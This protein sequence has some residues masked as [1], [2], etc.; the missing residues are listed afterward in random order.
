MVRLQFRQLVADVFPIWGK[1]MKIPN[2]RHVL[3]ALL[4]LALA[5]G[6]AAAQITT[7]TIT[8]SVKDE[9]GAILPGVSVTVK[10]VDTGITRNVITD[11][12]GNYEASNLSL[13]AYEVTAELSGFQTSVRSGITLTVGRSA[14]VT[15]ALKVGEISEKVTVTGEA[16][17]VETTRSEVAD[18]VST[19]KI[20][21]LPLNGRSYTELALL[22]A[23][24]STLGSSG[25][26]SIA[27][28]GAKLSIAGTRSS[29][30]AFYVD[31]T[32][33]K[34]PFGHSPG[35]AGGQTLGVEAIRE[36]SVLVST[37]SSEY[38]GSG[39]VINSVSKSGTNSIHG[40]VFE[41]LRNSA[42]DARNFF[43]PGKN[44]PPF[45]RNQYGFSIGGPIAKDRTFFF[46][47]YEA[48]K[49]RLATTSTLN[50]PNQRA[51]EG[52]IPDGPGGAE[53][54]YVLHPQ[55][56]KYLD[57]FPLPNGRINN[58]GTGDFI[59]SNSQPTDENFFTIKVDHQLS[60][61]DSVFVRYTFDD[62]DQI[63]P[64]SFPQFYQPLFTRYQYVTIEENKIFSPKWLNT[65][66]FGFNRS[67]GGDI[68]MMRNLDPNLYAVIKLPERISPSLQ[69]TGLSTFGP[70]ATGDRFALVNSFQ[71]TDK[72]SFTGGRHSIRLGTD[73]TRI[74]YNGA[75]RSRIHGNVRFN[76]LRDFFEGRVLL[77]EYMVPG[78]GNLRGFRQNEIAFYVQDD[79]KVTSRFT[80]NLGLRLEFVTIPTE[81]AGRISNVR[82]PLKDKASTVGDPFF[83][84]PKNNWGPRFGFAWDPTG[85]GNMSLRGGFGLFYQ[86]MTYTYW[87]LPAM[88]NDPYFLRASLANTTFPPPWDA[89]VGTPVLQPG[90]IQFDMKTPYV[91]HYN[92]SLQRQ[93]PGQAVITASY[94]GSHGVHIGRFFNQNTNTF[95]IRPDGSKFFLPGPSGT[96]G[97][98]LNP[99]FESVDLRQFDSN[100]LYN[101]FQLRAQ[102]RFA[103]GIQAQG[104][105]TF[106]RSIDEASNDSGL[107]SGCW[108]VT[109][110]DPYD[111]SRDRGLSCFDLR[112]NL[113]LNF[114]YD[115]PGADMRG[116][117]GQLI[118]GWKLGG[119]ANFH[120]GA[121][122]VVI[123]GFQHSRIG[124]TGT[125][126]QA[127]RPN[128]KPGAS[129]N[130][131]L[132]GPDRYLDPSSFVLQEAGTMGDLGR[133]TIISPG[134]AT[135]NGSLA[136]DFRITE[137]RKVEFRAE[138]FNLFNRANF[139]PANGSVFTSA[140][141]VVPSNFGRIS[142]TIT[143]ARQIQ[144]G[145]KVVF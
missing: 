44:P 134:L 135:F 24:V 125:A 100:T 53:R 92:L 29:N 101:S 52:F 113:S 69:T 90:P 7:A 130:P 107:G 10:N 38:S 15:F 97:P 104:S 36:F 110:M 66:R 76:T 82:E 9:S 48:L 105:Y 46:G 60:D 85:S 30:T 23:G 88:Q 70:A 43:D 95:I 54:A 132:G 78:T 143:T 12:S 144:F 84:I 34:S 33:V 140:N 77:F 64:Q 62:A 18:L 32:D 108:D 87:R 128:L 63:N 28:G 118:G 67:G 27:G 121:P 106:S 115:M 49:E 50:V 58:N 13:G 138:F 2:Y 6:S 47:T 51:R 112:H 56:K 80:L 122:A 116:L 103:S 71:F 86:Q 4:A 75:T 123:L 31:G 83:Q 17:L 16:P 73:L 37:Y 139:G 114:G 109:S 98:R 111:R 39:G 145:L 137:E 59:T 40:T 96:G 45:K 68:N 94:V 74:Q 141:G 22:Q 72:V 14:V 81:V 119:I 26:G 65:F 89:V 126:S 1:T 102:K 21:D 120:T 127:G 79:F 99:A 136:K 133:N 20:E 129:N 41:F 55:I 5:A 61:K 124:N 8:G 3:V 11:D 25:F 93:L 35:S 91:M 19:K 57:A 131:V 142:S 117:L 42:L